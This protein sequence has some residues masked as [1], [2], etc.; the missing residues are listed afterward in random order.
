MAAAPSSEI[1]RAVQQ[2]YQAMQT[3]QADFMQTATH[4]NIMGQMETQ[5]LQGKLF[6]KKPGK[7]RWDYQTPSKR[8]YVSD[9]KTLWI[10]TPEENQVVKNHWDPSAMALQFLLGRGNIERDFQARSLTAD[11]KKTFK[12]T[13]GTW[14]FLTPTTKAE[15]QIT[16]LVVR[17]DET[18][19]LISE[20]WMVDALGSQTHW[21]FQRLRVNQALADSLFQFKIPKGAEVV[22]Y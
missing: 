12:I 2:R 7:L 19:Q 14:F 17:I 16:A 22:E 5:A 20:V 11:E 13:E 3:L 18:A 4:R 1:L 21:N 8:T 6:I 10:Y 15:G 9:G